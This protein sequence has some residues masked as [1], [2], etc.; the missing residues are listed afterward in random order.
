MAAEFSVLTPSRTDRP[1]QEKQ[2]VESNLLALGP[3][4]LLQ[5]PPRRCT[6]AAAA[7]TMC[8]L[9]QQEDGITINGERFGFETCEE[10]DLST[11]SVRCIAC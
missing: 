1:P 5:Q 6:A 10:T 2:D 7:F 4:R 9:A 8:A 11:K 3:L